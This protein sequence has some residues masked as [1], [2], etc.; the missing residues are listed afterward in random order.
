MDMPSPNAPISF[1]VRSRTLALIGAASGI[2]CAH[3]TAAQAPAWLRDH[4]LV[5]HLAAN[6]VAAAWSAI[7]G[8]NPE[9][10]SE[11]V[12]AITQSSRLLA[13]AVGATVA[14]DVPFALLGGDHSCAMGTWAGVAKSVRPRG[15]LGLLWVDAHMDS[16][17]PETSPSGFYHG[18]PLACLLGYGVRSLTS[19]ADP[20][21]A[22]KPE[23][24]AIVG[25][26]SF[27]PEEAA[28]LQRLGVRVFDMS[29]IAMRGLAAVMEEATTIVQTGTVASGVSIDLDAIDPTE[30]SAVGSPEPGG[31]SVAELC[32]AL[33]EFAVDP[34]VVGCEIVEFNPTLG[35]ACQ[36]AR[37]IEQLIV[38]FQGRRP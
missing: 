30:V 27:E 7:I 22:V 15:A 32:S 8:T 24:V 21:P 17:V 3:P 13:T 34:N 29:E 18:M 2:G 14:E 28:L 16:H 11:P 25:I 5:D 9:Q 1:D 10:S 33:T 12:A 19:I 26:R 31:L 20:E 4:D 23:N 37:A 35:H 36:T 6:G 38:A